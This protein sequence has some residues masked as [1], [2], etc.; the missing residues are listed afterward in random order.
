LSLKLLATDPPSSLVRAGRLRGQPQMRKD[1]GESS[2]AAM[3]FSYPPHCGQCSMSISNTRFNNCAQRMRPF[4][5]SVGVWSPSAAP[6]PPP[7]AASHSVPI[8]HESRSGADAALASVYPELAL[9]KVGALHEFHRLDHMVAAAVAPRRLELQYD[10][11]SAVHTEPF[12]GDRWAGDVVAKLFKS[13][14]AID[15][16]AHRDMHAEAVCIG[17]EC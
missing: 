3:S 14:L 1:G 17:A 5:L 10:V 12:V 11:P 4:V 15:C 16:N 8:P 7:Y 9:A 13:M 2:I 6:A